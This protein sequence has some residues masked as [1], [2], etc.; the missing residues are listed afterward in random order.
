MEFVRR[1]KGS[2]LCPFRRRGF[3]LIEL[4][5]VLVVL[6]VLAG[7]VVVSLTGRRQAYELETAAKDV[8]TALSYAQ[9]NARLNSRPYRVVFGEQ[10]D[11][12][13]IETQRSTEASDWQAA[14]GVPGR[15]HRMAGDVRVLATG[16]AEAMQTQGPYVVEFSAAGAASIDRLVLANTQRQ[17]ITIQIMLATGQ[18]EVSEV[19]DL[20]I[21]G[22][23]Y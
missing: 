18:V 20:Q 19:A 13:Q 6:G 10:G 15:R 23:A 9:A 21:G 4:L 12:I 16:H 3:T 7:G 2:P 5:L 14:I 8:A 11:N 1:I 17:A 22:G